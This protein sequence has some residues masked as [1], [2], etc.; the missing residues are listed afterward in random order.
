MINPESFVRQDMTILDFFLIIILWLCNQPVLG[1]IFKMLSI[2]D[3]NMLTVNLTPGSHYL[4]YLWNEKKCWCAISCVCSGSICSTFWPIIVK[5]HQIFSEKDKKLFLSIPTKN[6]GWVPHVTWGKNVIDQ[7]YCLTLRIE[8][9]W[10]QKW[11]GCSQTLCIIVFS[12]NELR[13]MT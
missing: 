10:V 4:E 8:A 9:I 7:L 13:S 3:F 1:K 12:Q 11:K 6:W 2:F 5:I